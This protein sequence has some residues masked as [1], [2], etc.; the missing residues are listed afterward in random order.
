MV[1]YFTEELSRTYAP[2]TSF[3]AVLLLRV[4]SYEL[5][6]E[7]PLRLATRAYRLH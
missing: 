2:V 1:Y 7:F 4:L 3:T 5:E 6:L